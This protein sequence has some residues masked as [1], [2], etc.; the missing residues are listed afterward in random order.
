MDH[1]E[2]IVF[3]SRLPLM[4]RLKLKPALMKLKPQW[5]KLDESKM[6]PM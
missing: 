1:L 6:R 5:K 3:V 4:S 2:G